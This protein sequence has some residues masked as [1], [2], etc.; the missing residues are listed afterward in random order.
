MYERGEISFA[1]AKSI[2]LD[3]YVGL[4]PDHDQSYAYFMYEN[5]FGKVDIEPV[6][7]VDTFAAIHV[8]FDPNFDGLVNK[9]NGRHDED[10]HSASCK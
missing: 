7:Y 8:G 6:G 5:L 9:Q 10:G 1:H 3:E 2:N 4:T